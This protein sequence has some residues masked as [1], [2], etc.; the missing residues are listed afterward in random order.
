MS[1]HSCPDLTVVMLKLTCILVRKRDA[2][3][4]GC[5][6]VV[7]SLSAWAVLYV[8]GV[9]A[10]NI[11]ISGLRRRVLLTKI[12]EWNLR[13]CILDAM[14]DKNFRIKHEFKVLRTL[15]MSVHHSCLSYLY[16][17]HTH[18]AYHLTWNGGAEKLCSHA[19]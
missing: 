13:Y 3:P 2:A 4:S 8:Q 14:F 6:T 19:V 1:K 18:K 15:F 11:P 9:L 12:M 5:L 7:I 17:H 16:I 10:L